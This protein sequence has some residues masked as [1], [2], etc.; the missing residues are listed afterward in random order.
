MFAR[1]CSMIA[2]ALAGTLFGCSF[3]DDAVFLSTYGMTLQEFNAAEARRDAALAAIGADLGITIEQCHEFQDSPKGEAIRRLAGFETLSS[4]QIDLA[5]SDYETTKRIIDACLFLF[6][7]RLK[8][9]PQRLDTA[10]QPTGSRG[11]PSRSSSPPHGRDVSVDAYG[12]GLNADQYGRPHLYRLNDGVRLPG[13]FS[14]GVQRDAYGLGVHM[15]QFG[16]PVYD[17][18][19]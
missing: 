16:R 1:Q 18:A 9:P 4:E 11:L 6:E 17:S 8:L 19:P 10:T 5:L 12:L 3:I 13:I 15:D 14:G 7:A 2:C